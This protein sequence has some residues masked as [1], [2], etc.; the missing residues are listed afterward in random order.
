MLPFFYQVRLS[1]GLDSGGQPWQKVPLPHWAVLVVLVPFCF[2]ATFYAEMS[3]WHSNFKRH[4][5]PLKK[6]NKTKQNKSN[7][8]KADTPSYLTGP[9]FRTPAHVA[10]W[11][12]LNRLP[13]AGIRSSLIRM[14][15]SRHAVAFVK[16]NKAFPITHCAQNC[17]SHL[18][19]MTPQLPFFP[20]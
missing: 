3:E 16:E 15:L 2:R 8:I 14:V 4:N 19:D 18:M 7:K 1:Q 12:L 6:I 11:G 13:Q 17:L 5:S 20:S 10:L 9:V